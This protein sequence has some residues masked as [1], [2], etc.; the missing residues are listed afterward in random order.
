MF[1]LLVLVWKAMIF[2]GRNF[3]MVFLFSYVGKEYQRFPFPFPR[4][5][6]GLNEM[7]VKSSKVQI[8]GSKFVL[9]FPF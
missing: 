3:P 1:W 5:I 6:F 7:R 2:P 8:K 9:N 4:G